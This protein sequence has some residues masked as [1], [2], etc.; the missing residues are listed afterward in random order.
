MEHLFND[1]DYCLEVCKH[2]FYNKKLSTTGFYNALR[3][4]CK[5]NNEDFII[6]LLKDDRIKPNDINL[7]AGILGDNIKS[8]NISLLFRAF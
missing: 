8:N 1:N 6:D 5:F 3:E 2:A 4:V 7:S